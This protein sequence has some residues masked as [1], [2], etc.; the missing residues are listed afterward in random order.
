MV[1]L[2]YE[3]CKENVSLFVKRKILKDENSLRK[4]AA[5]L[6]TSAPMILQFSTKESFP[7]SDILKAMA[8]MFF[9]TVDNI[10]QGK[11]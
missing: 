4:I 6:G 1:L 5:E 2:S 7:T 10:L 3:Q 11:I 9:T 8:H